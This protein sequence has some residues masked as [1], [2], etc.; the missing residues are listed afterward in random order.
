M[1]KLMKLPIPLIV[2]FVFITQVAI[3]Q[4]NRYQVV[5]KAITVD[6][7]TTDWSGI[8]ANRVFEASHLWV[9]QGMEKENWKGPADLSFS[10]KAA[11]QNNRL[12]FLFVVTDDV[13]CKFNQPNTWLNDC[14]EICL[15]PR[16]SK[17]I[18]KETK[19][20][21][22]ILH[23]YEM[24]FLPSIPAHAFLLD[25]QSLYFTNKNQD[26]DFRNKWNGEI[27]VK[28]TSSGYIMELAFS[29]PDLKLTPDTKVGIEIAV[30]DDDGAGRKSLLT[31]TG[32]QCDYWISMD[33]YGELT[34]K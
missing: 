25:D 24:H 6:A 4:N 20:G 28:Y 14:V 23:G 31:W 29:V 21:K 33:N 7:D 9:G 8:S 15:D 3:S 1:V 10:W 32:K 27:A 13:I 26:Q 2:I 12:Y 5:N 11:R 34:F 30:C 18:R 19:A 22:T 17:G 16:N